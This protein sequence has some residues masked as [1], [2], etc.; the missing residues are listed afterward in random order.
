MARERKQLDLFTPS[1]VKPRLRDLTDVMDICFL[2]LAKRRLKPIRYQ[3]GKVSVL[4]TANATY[5]MA[6]IWDWDVI[7]GLVSMINESRNEDLWTSPRIGFP[8][9]NLLECIGRAKGG[10]NYHELAAAIHRLHFTGITTNIRLDDQHGE[11][12]PFSFI[13][14]YR[15]PERYSA[16]GMA[17]C[18]T[19]RPDPSRKWE[20]S[21][22]PWVYNA[23]V[24]QN[25]ILSVDRAFL[26]LRGGVEKFLYRYARKAVPASKGRWKIKIVKLFEKSGSCGNLYD[27]QKKV[28]E[29]ACRNVLPGY[30]LELTGGGRDSLVWFFQDRPGAPQMSWPSSNPETVLDDHIPF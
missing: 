9:Y 25:G 2:S 4:I 8:P 3:N 22:S 26:S 11:E 14:D 28:R 1:I 15:I 17:K 7:I 12:R 20:V 10:A 6:T 16:F 13:E 30:R 27:F 21:L 19:V 5:G 29:I 24:R 18:E 23:V